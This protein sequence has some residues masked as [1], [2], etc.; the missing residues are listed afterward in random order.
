MPL[1][2]SKFSKRLRDEMGKFHIE[3]FRI[4]SH[5]TQPGAPDIHWLF[6]LGSGTTGW[7]ETKFC[8]KE[9]KRVSY[10]PQQAPWLQSYARKGGNACTLV[11]CGDVD[12]VVYVPGNESLVAEKDLQRCLGARY[13][14]V[15]QGTDGW[16]K[17]AKLILGCKTE[18]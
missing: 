15:A 11:Y 17:L 5:S 18:V 2:E 7:I 14:S 10:R 3:S 9:P 16:K 12:I 1:A 4:E 13:I 6:T 8:A